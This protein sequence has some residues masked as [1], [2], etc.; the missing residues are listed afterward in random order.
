MPPSSHRFAVLVAV[1][2]VTVILL[3]IG[4]VAHLGWVVENFLPT[5]LSPLHALPGDLHAAG[6]PYREVFRAADWLAGAAFVL[7]GPPLLRIAPVHWQGRLTVVTVCLF[8]VLLLVHATYPPDCV[9][10]ESRPCPQ[11]HHAF[12]AQHIHDVTSLLLMLNYM[13]SPGVLALWWRGVWRAVALAVFAVEVLAVLTI[14]VLVLAGSEQFVGLAARV[15]LLGATVVLGIGIV[16]LIRV[17]RGNFDRQERRR[18][19]R[20]TLPAEHRVRTGGLS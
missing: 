8:G 11:D 2:T 7:A 16:Y 9:L 13:V 1:R 4:T 5:E 10:P 20:Q 3:L 19:H 6:Q 15:Q 14:G 18:G 17:G 12:A